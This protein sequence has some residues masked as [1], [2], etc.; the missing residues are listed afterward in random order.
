MAVIIQ[1]LTFRLWE[2]ALLIDRCQDTIKHN[3]NNI[4]ILDCQRSDCM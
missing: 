3:H 2:A 4:E 1:N